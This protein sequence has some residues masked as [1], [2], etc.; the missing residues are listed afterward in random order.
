MGKNANRGCDLNTYQICREEIVV[1]D[2][3]AMDCSYADWLE[4]G[5]AP[6]A[7]VGDFGGKPVVAPA[8]H[9]VSHAWGFNFQMLIRALQFFTQQSCDRAE[10]NTGIY[11]WIDIFVVN[12]HKALRGE[13]S[14]DYWETT[15]RLTVDAIG[16]TVVVLDNIPAAVPTVFSRCWCIWELFSTAEKGA[17]KLSVAVDASRNGEMVDMQ[18]ITDPAVMTALLRS[19][20]AIDSFSAEATVEADRVKINSLIAASEVGHDTIDTTVKQT[21]RGF[22]LSLLVHIAS[23]DNDM[24][25]GTVAEFLQQPEPFALDFRFHGQ[26]PLTLAL[27]KPK[28][29][30]AALLESAGAV[31]DECV[32]LDMNGFN[33][34]RL[35]SLPLGILRLTSLTDLNLSNHLL[36][37]LPDELP[38]LDALRRLDLSI[39]RFEQIPAAVFELRALESL[40]LSNNQ[41]HEV[42]D[43]IE[44][45]V[46][47]EELD[48][49]LNSPIS[50]LPECIT[51]RALPRLKRVAFKGSTDRE[52]ATTILLGRI[53]SQAALGD[54]SAAVV[55]ELRLCSRSSEGEGGGG[56][57]GGGG[58][59]ASYGEEETLYFVRLSTTMHGG[60]GNKA[61]VA[62]LRLNKA[63]V[64]TMGFHRMYWERGHNKNL[65]A[66]I[67]DEYGHF[68]SPHKELGKSGSSQ[69]FE[70][71]SLHWN[72][73]RAMW[74]TLTK[75]QP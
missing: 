14:E 53:A 50:A 7:I 30:I 44:G 42:P 33:F 9:F 65:G 52:I 35:D 2:T 66:P 17:N 70:R 74:E 10:V 45:L 32:A 46:K 63:F 64:T 31:P 54:A 28:P 24:H 12:Q 68:N 22:V 1:P 25:V 11:F 20:E 67:G 3:Q 55:D 16:H 29:R 75:D 71:G 51:S 6:A 26:C 60:W 23:D 43:A 15:F 41:L 37:D 36:T 59:A 48:V 4:S 39:N 18:G 13:M 40:N 47:L 21:M 72:P 19:I 57:G 62:N 69:D 38:S 61:L 5:Q 8:T 49:S 34:K 56:E 73:A 27:T 58:G